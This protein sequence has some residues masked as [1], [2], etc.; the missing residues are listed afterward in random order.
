M[1]EKKIAT[2]LI[3]ILED[4]C[5]QVRTKTSIIEDGV[6]LSSAFHRHVVTPGQDYAQEN[7]KVQAICEVVQTPEIISAYQT[8]NLNKQ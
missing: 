4:G 6:E 5:V 1:L 2:D 8:N 7:P 3:E